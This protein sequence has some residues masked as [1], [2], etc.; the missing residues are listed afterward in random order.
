MTLSRIVELLPPPTN[1]S[2][3]G[4]GNWGALP[5]EFGGRFPDTYVDF[6]STYG[7]GSIGAFLW[8]LNPFSKNSSLHLDQARYFRDAYQS[9]QEDFPQYYPRKPNDFLPWAFTDNGDAIVWVT[10]DGDPNEWHVCVQSSDPA[11][12][13]M[14]YLNTQDFLE[15]LLEKRLTSSILPMDFLVSE[16]AFEAQ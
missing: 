5:E 11:Q 8:V 3:Q 16:K 7:T 1:T 15:A 2:E 10:D 13:E 12:E 9:L 14:T 4:R 6:V